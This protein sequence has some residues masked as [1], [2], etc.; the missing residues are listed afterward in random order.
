MPE[1]DK[2]TPTDQKTDRQKEQDNGLVV[3]YTTLRN[4]IGFGGMLLPIRV[5][6]FNERGE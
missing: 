3:S 4:L 6:V 5:D 1:P 2:P